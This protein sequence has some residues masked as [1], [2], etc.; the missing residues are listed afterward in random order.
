MGAIQSP[1]AVQAA[2]VGAAGGD[3]AGNY[4][5]PT[6]AGIEHITA[7]GDLSGSFPNP[8]VTGLHVATPQTASVTVSGTVA[9]TLALAGPTI[10]SGGN[11]AGLCYRFELAGIVTTTATTQ[12]VT[13][14]LRLGGVAGTQL[15]SMQINPDS[16]ATVTN[17][18][19]S[20]SGFVLF[21]TATATTAKCQV[22]S[23]F[24]PSSV[25]QST[26]TVTNAS[27]QQL[28][29]T[30]TPSATAVSLTVNGGF[31]HKVN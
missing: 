30:Y 28:V 3:L 5:N 10:S 2:P 22:D 12:T 21:N 27:A 20:A 14:N 18:E 16:S 23:N 13:V 29:V 31:W 19:W 26:A 9:E 1:Y 24:F 11:Y 17:T 6:V 8:T 4:P 7:G 15:L 25:Q